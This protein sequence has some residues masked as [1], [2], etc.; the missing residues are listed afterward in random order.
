MPLRCRQTLEPPPDPAWCLPSVNLA[1][2]APT[3]SRQGLS[4]LPSTSS[5]E[6]KGWGTGWYDTLRPSLPGPL[7]WRE[8]SAATLGERNFPSLPS[9]LHWPRVC[10]SLSAS[11]LSGFSWCQGSGRPWLAQALTFSSHPRPRPQVKSLT[12][13]SSQMKT[14]MHV[15]VCPEARVLGSTMG[16]GSWEKPSGCFRGGC[17][18]D[19]PAL[20]SFS[21]PKGEVTDPWDHFLTGSPCQA[22]SLITLLGSSDNSHQ[23]LNAKHV[24]SVV[25]HTSHASSFNPQSNPGHS[26]IIIPGLGGLRVSVTCL[27]TRVDAWARVQGLKHQS[28]HFPA[29]SPPLHPIIPLLSEARVLSL[30]STMDLV[31]SL[32]K[33][34]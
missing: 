19:F 26:P 34:L 11:I 24:A 15:S 18:S 31:M 30:T 27:P 25:L 1:L 8:E 7:G 5:K 29:S 23:A 32:L 6:T 33:P 2:L 10:L 3:L 16:G 21:A 13:S 28:Q 20:L 4:C 17:P 9:S 12:H 22:T 14:E